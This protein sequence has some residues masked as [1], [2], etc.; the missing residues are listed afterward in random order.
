MDGVVPGRLSATLLA[1]LK[2]G[3]PTTRAWSPPAIAPEFLNN[4]MKDFMDPAD[5]Q[6]SAV[7]QQPDFDPYPKNQKALEQ[8][9]IVGEGRPPALRREAPAPRVPRESTALIQ[10]DKFTTVG[11][12]DARPPVFKSRLPL[13]L[14]QVLLRGGGPGSRSRSPVRSGS[15]DGHITS[16]V[17][18]V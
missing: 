13:G 2:G 9:V 1:G 11:K 6:G 5:V 18:D 4:H 16:R 15:A 3:P 12:F 10:T 8:F 17:T 14:Y 7:P